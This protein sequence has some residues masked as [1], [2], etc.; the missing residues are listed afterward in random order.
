MHP[1]V[2]TPPT[3]RRRYSMSQ[4]VAV[5][6]RSEGRCGICQGQ[7]DPEQVSIDHI[8][9]VARGGADE[10]DNWQL[11]HRRCNSSQ[12][13]EPGTVWVSVAE[14]AARLSLRER[15]VRKRIAAGRLPAERTPD[16]WRVCIPA[17]LRPEPAPADDLVAQLQAVVAE[18]RAELEARRREVQELH[19]IV[20]RLVSGS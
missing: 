10:P 14:A 15:A 5:Y 8:V 4:L 6:Q 7:V 18:Q 13:V 12:G 11:A 17:A 19:A 2:S 20:Q 1:E 9:A 3:R 16:G